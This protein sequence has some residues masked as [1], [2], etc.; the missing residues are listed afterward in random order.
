MCVHLCKKKG[1]KKTPQKQ[2]AGEGGRLSSKGIAEATNSL[3]LQGTL[4]HLDSNHFVLQNTE[5][6]ENGAPGEA[7]G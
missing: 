2:T 3:D 1:G 6:G 4:N 7:Y 5:T